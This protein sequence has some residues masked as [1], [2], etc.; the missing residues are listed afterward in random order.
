MLS[1]FEIKTISWL[2]KSEGS[3]SQFWLHVNMYGSPLAF[4]DDS[5]FIVFFKIYYLNFDFEY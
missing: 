3:L 4:L 5:Q 1:L 2:V